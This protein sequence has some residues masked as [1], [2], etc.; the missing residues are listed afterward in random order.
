[1]TLITN[2]KFDKGSR[3]FFKFDDENQR[4]VAAV[5]SIPAALKKFVDEEGVLT[6][7]NTSTLFLK[8]CMKSSKVEK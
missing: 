1:M 3:G 7:Q 2:A 6:P 4:I 8:R 5:K